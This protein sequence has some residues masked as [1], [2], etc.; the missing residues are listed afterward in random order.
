MFISSE[1]EV[2]VQLNVCPSEAIVGAIHYD[3]PRQH[4]LIALR[5]TVPLELRYFYRI[6]EIKQARARKQH[7]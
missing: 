1:R 7:V 3:V 4:I 6:A 5:G 2:S